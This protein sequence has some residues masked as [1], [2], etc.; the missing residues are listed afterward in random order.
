MVTHY[1]MFIAYNLDSA[2]YLGKLTNFVVW[3]V[4][5]SKAEFVSDNGSFLMLTSIKADDSL[6]ASLLYF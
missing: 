4:A 6:T 5:I 1:K 3:T 2:I